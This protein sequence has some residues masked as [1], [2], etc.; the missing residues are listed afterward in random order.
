MILDVVEAIALELLGGERNGLAD[1]SYEGMTYDGLRAEI[2]EMSSPE[3]LR[4][5]L[6]AIEAKRS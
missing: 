2:E 3:L 1:W 6:G 5:L 4:D